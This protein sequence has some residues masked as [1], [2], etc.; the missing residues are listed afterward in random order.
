MNQLVR[1]LNT[2]ADRFNVSLEYGPQPEHKAWAYPDTRWNKYMKILASDLVKE[3]NSNAYFYA[4]HE[5][6]HVA[7]TKLER[8]LERGYISAMVEGLVS[9]EVY[10]TELDAWIWAIQHSIIPVTPEM[11]AS[12]RV[13]L[14]TYEYGLVEIG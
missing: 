9:Y 10:A 7:T 11:L 3:G 5:F 6:G 14:K 4:M 2:L 8:K 12:M 13:G 1:H